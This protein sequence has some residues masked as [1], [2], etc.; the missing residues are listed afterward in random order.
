MGAGNARHPP[1]CPAS[2]PAQPQGASADPVL[3]EEGKPKNRI[4]RRSPLYEEKKLQRE[5]T[6]TKLGVTARISRSNI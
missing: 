1:L 4:F 5:K 3:S 6:V 2:A